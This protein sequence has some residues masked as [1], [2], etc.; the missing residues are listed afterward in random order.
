MVFTVIHEGGM[1]DVDVGEYARLLLQRGQDLA[2]LR[3]I[4]EPGS[5]RRWVPAWDEEQEARAFAEELRERT[6]DEAWLVVPSEAQPGV[7]PLG[8]VEISAGRHGDA[9]TFALH[10]LSQV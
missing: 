1:K 4:P 5:D 7:G 10:P 6:R 2:N 9:W 8:P 3:R